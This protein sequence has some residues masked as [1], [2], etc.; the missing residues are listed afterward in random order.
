MDMSY[1][2]AMLYARHFPESAR[3][4][5]RARAWMNVTIA[6][7]SMLS[8]PKERAFQSVF[9]RNGLAQ[10]EVRERR[11]MEALK[12]L[13]EGM[14]R[15]DAELEPDEHA[16]H[17]AVLR[18]NRAQVYGG[19]GR[20][21]EALADY[22]AVIA[23]DPNFPEHHFN[24]GTML[25]MLG[26]NEEALAAFQHSLD[27]SL[28]YPEAYYNIGDARLEMGDIQGA[29]D[30]FSYALE[31]DP[32][33]VEARVNR[34]G[35]LYQEG[36]NDGAW[37]DVM[38]GLRWAPNNVHLLCLKGSLL[39]ERGDTEGAMQALSQAVSIDENFA[40]AWA[41][42][43]VLALQLDDTAAAITDLSRALELNDAPDTRY[44]RGLAKE[45]SGDFQQAVADYDAI[46]AQVD[47]PDA[48]ARRELCLS[49]S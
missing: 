29:L 9:A 44:N 18:Y 39:A 27:I 8:D 31:L 7:A 24:A 14:A 48:M 1:G 40:E 5:T 19:T 4:Y 33:H 22:Q 20:W 34:G 16:L 41:A 3:D 2:M 28:P 32:K 30:A 26:R 43:G 42:R 17:R 12:L 21:A 25:R 45:K 10:V 15:L 37:S 6:F 13:E 47:D 49:R 46:L 35:L 23:L 38:A 36:D 11:P